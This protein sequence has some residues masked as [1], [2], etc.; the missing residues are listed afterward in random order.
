LAGSYD[1]SWKP[2][3]IRYP[4]V[5]E[6]SAL[7]A[8]FVTAFVALAPDRL[9]PPDYVAV[10]VAFSIPLAFFSVAVALTVVENLGALAFLY[11]GLVTLFGAFIST[12]LQV[13]KASRVPPTSLPPPQP[14][15]DAVG[16]T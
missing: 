8:T 15:G 14:Q 1:W 12:I 9:K 10:L 5:A 6:S 16:G 7:L 2:T 3:A 4:D 13:V 11:L